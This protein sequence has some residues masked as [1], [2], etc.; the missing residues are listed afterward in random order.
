MACFIGWWIAFSAAKANDLNINYD[1]MLSTDE[2]PK[3]IVSA[4]EVI[5][6]ITVQIEINGTEHNFVEEN[7]PSEAEI[8]FSWKQPFG[9][10][11]ANASIEVLYASGEQESM[12]FPMA[13][14]YGDSLTVDYDTL[15]VDSEENIL[16]VAVTGYVETAEVV[17][18]GIDKR[19]VSQQSVEIRSGPGEIRIPWQGKKQ[20]VILLD[21][22]LR[23]ADSFAGFSYSPWSIEIPHQ[24]V[25]FAKE[26]AEIPPEEESK[27]EESLNELLWLSKRYGS[28]IPVRLYVIGCTDQA[29]D[30]VRNIAL[31]QARARVIATWFREHG[32]PEPILFFGLGESMLLVETKD[33]GRKRERQRV[34]YVL[35]SEPP[36]AFPKVA[37]QEVSE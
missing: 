19:V 17:A 22:T 35:S 26:S 11:S 3:L 4:S 12:L 30:D 14:S 32:Y 27:L 36:A 25:V 24:E 34:L 33:G 2:D 13:F 31:S 6:R 18:L 10:P 5:K 37:W 9:Y 7:Q 20:D 29:G 23:D 15:S 28:V 8:S 21:I 16:T 1:P